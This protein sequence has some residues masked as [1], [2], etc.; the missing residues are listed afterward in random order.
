V[1][2]QP[3]ASAARTSDKNPLSFAEKRAIATGLTVEKLLMLQ[4]WNLDETEEI[5]TNCTNFGVG[6]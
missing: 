1:N 6:T 5:D 4:S 3:N 2:C